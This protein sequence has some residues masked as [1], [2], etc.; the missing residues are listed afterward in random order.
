MIFRRKT[1]YNKFRSRTVSKLRQNTMIISASRRTDIPAWYSDWFFNRIKE[2]F[3]YVRNPMNP[4]QISK[5]ELSPEVVDC[6]VFWTKNPAPM[7]DRLD[8]LSGYQYYFQFTLTGYGTDIESGLPSKKEVLIPTFQRLSEKI[9]SRRV[10]WRYDPILFTDRYT[11]EYHVKAFSQIA[12]VL[13]GYTEKCVISFVDMYAKIKKSMDAL[14]IYNLE[15]TQL[16]EFA[17]QLSE[18]AHRNRME[19]GSCAEAIDLSACGIRHNCCIDPKL[20]EELIGCRI[21]AGKDKNQRAECGCAESI[22]IGTYNTCK[23]GCRY[24]YANHSSDSV[25]KNFS[26]FDPLSPLLCG[27][28]T[29]NDKISMR[30]MKSLK[31]EQMS[32]FD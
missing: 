18:I 7:I 23:N 9:G 17:G 11:P 27:A 5:I 16:T 10:I 30:I 12:E 8:E 6:I 24:C 21:S 26:G 28:V 22:D 3:V 1:R 14:K 20:I 31:A 13:N 32:L 25:E 29:E 2:G 19:I 4:R 15:E